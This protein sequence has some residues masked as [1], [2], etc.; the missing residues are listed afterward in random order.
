MATDDLTNLGFKESYNVNE[1][2]EDIDAIKAG[3]VGKYDQAKE[4]TGFVAGLSG[5][6]TDA[7]YEKSE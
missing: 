2:G 1:S 4:K 7:K 3:W 5:Y 6:A